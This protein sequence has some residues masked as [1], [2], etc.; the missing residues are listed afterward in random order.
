MAKIDRLFA[1]RQGR[2]PRAGKTPR[3]EI[4]EWLESLVKFQTAEERAKASMIAIQTASLISSVPKSFV[5]MDWGSIL[6]TANGTFRS[7][8]PEAVFLPD[9]TMAQLNT[10]TSISEVHPDLA[11][12]SATVEALRKLGLVPASAIS[13]FTESARRALGFG[14]DT[15]NKMW[16]AF[17]RL[18][19]QVEV[20]DA[21]PDHQRDHK[22]DH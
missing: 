21:V 10:P 17:W 15:S 3:A 11:A 19:R 2:L 4:S 22:G 13:R 12:D 8:N 6:L 14:T 1:V 18:S 16:D 5:P 7:P 20:G 9:E